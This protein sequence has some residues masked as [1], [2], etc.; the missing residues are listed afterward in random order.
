M[1]IWWTGVVGRQRAGSPILRGGQGRRVDGHPR[2]RIPTLD[3][4]LGRRLDLGSFDHQRANASRA[5]RVDNAAAGKCRQQAQVYQPLLRPGAIG[6]APAA[7]RRH[8]AAHQDQTGHV[9]H[10]EPA[11]HEQAPQ[12]RAQQ[13]G[14]IQPADGQ[15]DFRHDRRDD[16]AHKI[17]RQGAGRGRH[18]QREKAHHALVDRQWNQA[19]HHQRDRNAQGQ[20]NAPRTEHAVQ[21]FARKQSGPK[22]NPGRPG[23]G[24]QHG[25]RDGEEREVVPGG[26]AQ[27]PD[28]Q[29][30]QGKRRKGDG[31]EAQ[32]DVH[33][34]PLEQR[35]RE[36]RIGPG[37][38]PHGLGRPRPAK[39]NA[40]GSH[41][42]PTRK[43]GRHKRGT[44]R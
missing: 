23:S 18:Q 27:Q 25:R 4:V 22:V 1:R 14:G 11:Q 32:V 15:I 7:E 44:P 36:G 8:A 31:K 38:P 39:V 26:N 34:S 20:V 30:F 9:H 17:K 16:H 41:T 28:Q 3:R 13:V 19:E 6:K 24:A 37:L 2:K 12:R 42:R 43:R 21:I 5:D 40:A 10:F 33:F 29:D 35:C